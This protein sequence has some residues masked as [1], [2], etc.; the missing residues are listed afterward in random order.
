[1][2]L[3]QRM[4]MRLI[5]V[6]SLF[7]LVMPMLVVAQ[8]TDAEQTQ[9]K[10]LIESAKATVAEIHGSQT[11]DGQAVA[12]E[13]IGP[14]YTFVEPVRKVASGTIWIW[15]N[16]GRPAAVLS[17]STIN[18][19]RFFEFHSFSDLPLD[20]E[21][22]GEKWQPGATW[23]GTEIPEAPVPAESASKRLSQIKQIA[24]RFRTSNVDRGN[25]KVT[26]MRILPQPIYRYPNSTREKDGAVFLI[27]R[28]GDPEAVLFLE[29]FSRADGTLGWQFMAGCLTVNFVDVF[30]DE[31]PYR[32]P[33]ELGP[34]ERYFIVRKA[35]ESNE[36]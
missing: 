22:L 27:S 4:N 19:I 32:L 15:G 3:S 33:R 31:K 14:V 21:I 30:L 34:R 11:A 2:R 26:P 16:T 7:A 8:E 36:K 10:K 9:T 23:T 6:T 28:D 1:M 18:T 29:T 17:L 13:A 35:A 24:A 20:F 25:G 5:F 12:L